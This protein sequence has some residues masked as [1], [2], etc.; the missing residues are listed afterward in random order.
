M[1]ALIGPKPMVYKGKNYN[2]RALI[3]FVTVIKHSGHLTTL[4]KFRKHSPAARVFNIS[5]VF[6]N[7]HRVYHR[8]THGLG[9]LIC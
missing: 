2:K 4:E 1:R 6:S 5:L 7:A 9:F 8:V 3:F